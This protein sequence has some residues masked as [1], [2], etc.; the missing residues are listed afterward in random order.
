MLRISNTS[1]SQL[2]SRFANSIA[3]EVRK[4]K[5]NHSVYKDRLG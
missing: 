1:V 4:P 5:E 2:P 3:D